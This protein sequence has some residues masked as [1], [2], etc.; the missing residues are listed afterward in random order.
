MRNAGEVLT[1]G[2]S[3]HPIDLFTELLRGA[4]VEAIADVRRYPGSRRNPQF[5]AAALEVSLAEA[6]IAMVAFGEGSAAGALRRSWRSPQRGLAQL[7]APPPITWRPRS[8]PPA[9]SAWRPRDRAADRGHVR[10]ADWRRCHRQLIADALLARAG[11]RSICSQTGAA[12]RRLSPHAVVGGPG[13]LPRPAAAGVV[14]ASSP[15]PRRR[16]DQQRL[17]GQ[18]GRVRAR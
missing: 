4:R 16:P 10:K 1:V 13:Q 9:S 14:R 12:S 17:A 15:A 7:V 18:A 11:A 6:G 2:H 5:R 8:S 3:N